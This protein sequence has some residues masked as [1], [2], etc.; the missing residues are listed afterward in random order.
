[1]AA[2]RVTAP[3]TVSPTT[4]PTTTTAAQPATPDGPEAAEPVVETS[5]DAAV[6]R[7]LSLAAEALEDG[8]YVEPIGANALYFFRSV[9]TAEPDNAE[10]QEGLRAISSELLARIEQALESG[11]VDAARTALAIVRSIDPDNPA[12]AEL[13]TRIGSRDVSAAIAAAQQ[14]ALAQDFVGALALL[15]DQPDSP[16]VNAARSSIRD[17]Q[18]AARVEASLQRLAVAIATGQLLE[19]DGNSARFHA[20][21][22]LALAPANAD[23]R[24]AVTGLG[25]LLVQEATTATAAGAFA[26]A[27]RWLEAAE[28][29]DVVVEPVAEARLAL[30]DAQAAADAERDREAQSARQLERSAE[31]L[32]AGAL[33][34]PADDSAYFHLT[35]ARASDPDNPALPAAEARLAEALLV[36]SEARVADDAPDDAA[37][38]LD[39]AQALGADADALSAQRQAVDEAIAL[40]DAIEA[41][42]FVSTRELTR[43]RYVPPEYPYVA[44]RRGLEGAVLLEFTLTVDGTVADIEV[45]ESNPGTTFD[46]AAITAL[47]GWEYEPYTTG[48][49]PREVRARVDMTF[50]L[51]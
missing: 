7:A 40:R 25:D 27:E 50:V 11:D 8:R 28:A 42:G 24:A 48:G 38:L 23:V 47:S 35:E 9:L 15:A 43:T 20:E 17:A 14:R 31:R 39:V 12:V 37:R 13:Q 26:D 18:R 21:A 34:D 44:Q 46:R 30:A 29:L 45:I 32:A 6:D 10:A 41:R 33:L 51:D 49:Q 36:A 1:L 3:A 19:P 2:R 16:D 22:A 4:T 5:R